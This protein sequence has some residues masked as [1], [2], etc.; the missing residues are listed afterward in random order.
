MQRAPEP[1]LPI[2]VL[3]NPVM[4]V[5]TLAT[6]CALGVMTGLMIYMPLYYQLVHKLT[7]TQSG[8]A[9]IPVVVMTT[10][11]SMSAGRAMM[12]LRHYKIMAYIGMAITVAAVAA[13]VVWPR[14]AIGLRDR[15]RRRHRLRRRHRVPDHDGV[16]P[17]RGRAPRDRRRH[18]RHELL[19]RAVRAR[20]WSR[21]WAP[22]CSP[23]SA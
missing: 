10:P 7:P 8:L 18:R 6:A 11:G 12:Y 2:H 3:A 17:E 5:G 23:A 4:R 22:S 20:S 1:F 13:L 9:L 21:S 16:D 15:R 19:P 14:D